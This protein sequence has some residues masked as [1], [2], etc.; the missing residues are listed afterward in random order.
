MTDLTGRALGR[1]LDA[2]HD[3]LITFRRHMHAH[4]ELSGEEYETTNAIVERLEVADLKPWV[5]SS[6]TGAIC[7][8]GTGD[9]PRVALRADIDALAMDD[10]K[11]V[12]YRSRFPGIAHACGHDVHTTVVLGAGLYLAAHADQLPGPIR[13]IFQPAEE[14]VPGGALTVIDDGGLHDVA[15]VYGVHCDPKLDIGHIGLRKGAITSASDMVEIELLG[16]GGHTARPELTVNMVTLAARVVDELPKRVSYE[17]ADR[18]A[19]KMVFG[20]I[21]S[22]EAGN[23]IPTH[24]RLL[25]TVRTPSVDAWE[26]LSAV[27]EQCVLAAVDGTGAEVRINYTTG[28]PPVLNS[29][30]EIALIDAAATAELGAEA[31]TEAIQSWGGDDFAWYLR[32][33]PGA[34]VRLGTHDPTTGHERHD[35]HIGKFDVDE[36]AIA[37]GIRLMVATTL[38]RFGATAGV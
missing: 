23:V 4:P 11:E 5:L 14:K 37:L 8:F 26:S 3:E 2:H 34:Y 35:L 7:D 30:E 13:L 1:W 15:A 29:A 21:R 24:A 12:H 19:V 9:G 6:G 31:V 22:G 17:L 18:A 27:V 32:E 10:E 33:V 38:A 16:P 20:S 28:I 36:R 25:A